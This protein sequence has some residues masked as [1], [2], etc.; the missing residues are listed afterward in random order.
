MAVWVV[1]IAWCGFVLV[2]PEIGDEVGRASLE[3]M[4][5]APTPPAV[6]APLPPPAN[7]PPARA[8]ADD[9]E[10]A[11]LL[12]GALGGDCPMN[13]LQLRLTLGPE[14]LLSAEALGPTP[15]CAGAAVW[16]APWP[17]MP[18]PVGVELTVSA[19]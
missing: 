1:V 16:G 11:A 10:S 14:G 12:G 13:G 7:G 17:Q 5:L 6:W 8:P 2:R 9:A 18:A 15:P 19:P 3:M 4:G